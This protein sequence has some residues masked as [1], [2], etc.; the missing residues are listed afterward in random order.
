MGLGMCIRLYWY[1]QKIWHMM[2]ARKIQTFVC[3]KFIKKFIYQLL[4]VWVCNTNPFK[5]PTNSL[6]YIAVWLTRFK[7]S[8]EITIYMVTVVQMFHSI[9]MSLSCIC[10]DCLWSRLIPKSICAEISPAD[11]WQ[12]WQQWLLARELDLSLLNYTLIKIGLLWISHGQFPKKR[13]V[14]P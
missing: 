1:Y 10:S 7:D 5:L 2:K 8:S 12:A 9:Y 11:T 14:P 3:K 4:D 6:N 13:A